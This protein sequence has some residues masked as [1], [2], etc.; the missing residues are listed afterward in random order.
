MLQELK[1]VA[2]T[3]ANRDGPLPPPASVVRRSIIICATPRSGSWMLSKSVESCAAVGTVHEWFVPFMMADRRH[4][5]GLPPDTGYIATARALIVE[6]GGKTGIFFVKIMWQTLLEVLEQL[7]KE[8]QG[9]GPLSDGQLLRR[10]FPNPTF[11]L[12]SRQEKVKQAVSYFKATQ[13]DLWCQDRPGAAR[14]LSHLMFDYHG[15]DRLLRYVTE[16]EDSWRRFLAE[17]ELPHLEIVHE[18]LVR[19][20]PAVMTDLL[21]RLQI[22]YDRAALSTMPTQ[23]QTDSINRE[24]HDRFTREAGLR[25]S[26]RPASLG[27][28]SPEDAPSLTL[29][30]EPERLDMRMGSFLPVEIHVS[31]TSSRGWE[32]GRSLA[33]GGEPTLRTRWRNPDGKPVE[34]GES[35]GEASLPLEIAPGDDV[36]IP[37][38]T[39]AP[40]ITGDYLI[41]AC[42]ATGAPGEGEHS[43]GH[44]RIPVA[45]K[46]HIWEE[47][48]RTCFSDARDERAPMRFLCWFGRVDAREFPWI[49]HQDHGWLCCEWNDNKLWYWYPGSTCGWFCTSLQSYPMVWSGRKKIWLQY[50]RGSHNPCQY[51]IHGTRQW[52]KVYPA[53]RA[54]R[55][56]G[57]LGSLMALL[58][59]DKQAPPGPLP[60]PPSSPGQLPARLSDSRP[61]I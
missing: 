32:L 58:R 17:Q 4:F 53:S 51:L 48:A 7:R 38:F 49:W 19:D 13:T 5:Y 26:A 30:M 11:V 40:A 41:E 9:E 59:R 14:D 20:Y 43:T 23:S 15:I 36:V 1:S 6:E 28:P 55:K 24:W 61:P 37:V 8:F 10:F 18:K 3:L 25:R 45:V 57:L 54:R 52:F 31:N 56:P 22:P 12:V 21:D 60:P 47:L 42:I 29:R 50:K 2:R 46:T 27:A 34:G 44:I 16:T 39:T 33:A 35:A